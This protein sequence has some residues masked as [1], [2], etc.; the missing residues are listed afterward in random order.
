MR[1]LLKNARA[2]QSGVFRKSDVLIADGRIAA[3]AESL[4][5]GG[6]RVLDCTDMFIF[7]GLADVH[8]HLREPGFSYKETIE[9]GT[10]AGAAGGF[11]ALCAMP[12]LRPAPD[13]PAH[14]REELD[15]IRAGARIPVYPYACLTSGGTGRGELLDYAAL[16]ADCVGFSDDG[17][18]VQSGDLMRRVMLAVRETGRP[19]AAHCEDE[20]LLRGGYIHDGDYA[21][22]HGHRGICPESE[23]GPIAR[24][25]ELVRETGCP[26]HV[27]HVSTKESAAL[28]REARR[29][30]LPVS[31][32]TAPHYLLLCDADLQEDGRFKMNPPLRSAKDRQA[33]LEAV[34][35]G[36]LDILVTDHA[37]H[38][39]E[40]KSRGLQG[41]AFGVVG[42]ET[43]LSA[44]WTALIEPGLIPPEKLAELMSV[45]PR[46]RF[47]L[48]E[49]VIVEDARADLCVFDPRGKHSVDASKFYSKGK[50]TPFDGMALCGR[51]KLTI[52]GNEVVFDA[53][54]W[55]EENRGI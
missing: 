29:E 16:A 30:G 52:F 54:D 23:W 28:L 21:R 42:L 3:C 11:T 34:V 41:S 43:A 40:E 8:V 13:S 1:L 15:L 39:A 6:A 49:A 5:C 36:T 12:N 18:G 31:G 14:L 33:I 4:S 46:K 19:I 26:Y 9:T 47:S 55:N 25:L 44:N 7:P 51:V 35:D 2:Y 20:T 37:P 45:N 48:P 27:C 17:K 24:D 50:S 53:G 32:E 10:L 38:S 22:A